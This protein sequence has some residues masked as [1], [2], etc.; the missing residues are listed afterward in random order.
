MLNTIKKLLFGKYH[1]NASI[2]DS[3]LTLFTPYSINIMYPLII[4]GFRHATGNNSG[5]LL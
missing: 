3:I 5:F 2:C 4:Q 1:L